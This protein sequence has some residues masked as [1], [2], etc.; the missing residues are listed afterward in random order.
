MDQ[1]DIFAVMSLLTSLLSISLMSV[2]F[3]RKTAATS[4]ANVNYPRFLVI[5]LYVVSW[6]FTTIAALLNSINA[7]NLMSCSLSIFVCICLYAASKIVIYL[8]LIEKV[9]VVSSVTTR[10][11]DT[12]LYRFNLLLL[13]PYTIILVLMIM[14]RVSILNENGHCYIGLKPLASITLVLYDIL[15]SCWL[16]V[17]FIRPLMSTRSALQGP[18]TAKLHSVARRSLIGSILSL[19]TS[20]GN[21]L[22]LVY[23][24]GYEDALLCLLTCTLDVTLNAVA[25][26]WVTSRDKALRGTHRSSRS[27]SSQNRYYGLNTEKQ[28]IDTQPSVTVASYS[29]HHPHY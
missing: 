11:K 5:A 16:T 20:S 15:M 2:L 12:G 24:R 3:G 26:H 21:V 7:G 22:S 8:F 19:L 25:V 18:S 17:L 28:T 13:T 6:S 27:S 10:R 14:N 9:Y 4:I 29:D 1:I 23:F